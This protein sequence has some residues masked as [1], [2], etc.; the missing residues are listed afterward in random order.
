MKITKE[1]LINFVNE[2]YGDFDDYIKLIDLIECSEIEK[3]IE[4]WKDI[5]FANIETMHLIYNYE[6]LDYLNEND[7][8][9]ISDAVI[10]WATYDIVDI[11]NYYLTE[12][13]ENDIYKL[14]ELVNK[15]SE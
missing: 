5:L 8:S 7:I 3:D 1:N 6:A 11:A 13:L 14:N 2:N 4:N 15:E 9:D 12:N 10:G